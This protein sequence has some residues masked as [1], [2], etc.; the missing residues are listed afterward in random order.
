MRYAL[1]FCMMLFSLNVA[2]TPSTDSKSISKQTCSL[3]LAPKLQAYCLK[4]IKK[5][6][7]RCRAQKN[8]FKQ[9]FDNTLHFIGNDILSDLVPCLK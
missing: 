9:L 6:K 7:L 8:C 3:G 4:K 2:E 5:E 1:I